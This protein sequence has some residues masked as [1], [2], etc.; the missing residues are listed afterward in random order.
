MNSS[1]HGI[2]AMEHESG[3]KITKLMSINNAGDGLYLNG[4]ADCFVSASEFENNDGIG[5]EGYNAF[6]ARIEYSDI[7]GNVGGGIRIWGASPAGSNA[8]VIVGN[9]FGG[10]SGHD[11]EVV[12]SDTFGYTS[13]Q[14]VITGNSFVG[15]GKRRTGSNSD[16]VHILGSFGNV[17][18]GNMFSAGAFPHSARYGIYIGDGPGGTKDEGR[19]AVGPNTFSLSFGT[20]D[21]V[22]T[23]TT[24]F[25][26]NVPS[27][28]NTMQCGANT[29]NAQL[30]ISAAAPTILSGFGAGASVQDANGTAAFT[31]NVGVG[32]TAK[33]GVIGL[34]LSKSGWVCSAVDLV[35]QSST[36][37]VTKQTGTTK[38][39]ATFAN[40]NT[41]GEHAPW[42]SEDLL[43]VS[44]FAR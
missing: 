7:G 22:G 24:Y 41:A 43:S 44:C 36:V 34:P 42:I 23:S 26:N 19:D 38:D 29:Y 28:A 21:Y 10:N 1:G 16:D 18:S 3:M 12:G 31:I 39:S 40:F 14:H 25:C 27:V 17:I 6:T 11:I 4:Y 30:L 37:F 13:T 9:E 8:W 32:G 33:N 2:E 35:T 5:I 15:G 20:G